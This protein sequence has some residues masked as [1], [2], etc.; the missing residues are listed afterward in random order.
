MVRETRA[1]DSLAR[2][3]CIAALLLVASLTVPS[4]S[5]AQVGAVPEPGPDLYEVSLVDGSVFV[6]RIVAVDDR[7]VTL[8]T[9]GGTEVV[10]ERAQL[11]EIRRA[12]G[13]VV[14]GTFWAQDPNDG[15]LFFSAT[16]RS[17]QKGEGYGGTYLIVLP[18]AAYGVTD[19]F[20]IGGGAPLLFGE[21][22]PFYITPKFQVIRSE[23]ASVSVG[24]LHFI[25]DGSNVGIAYGVA[26]LGSR[27]NALHVGVGFGYSGD[28]FVSEP[29]A[30]VGGESRVT[31]RVKLMTENYLL[32]DD[33]GLV[34]SGGLRYLGRRF[35]ADIGIAG[36]AGDRQGGCCLPL[37]NF[38]YAFGSAR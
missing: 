18:F 12:V 33:T 6:A 26:T 11:A 35:G 32:P 15:R 23:R 17:L 19:R 4:A 27:D 1:P 5:V 22:Q 2:A 13:Q 29:V 34:F 38:S 14:D 21:L 37:L 31:R 24:T 25:T 8:M 36:Y 10:V 7:R 20:T 28:D 3:G 30:M 9:S 16:G